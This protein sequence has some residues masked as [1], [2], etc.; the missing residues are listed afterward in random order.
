MDFLTASSIWETHY[1]TIMLR[2]VCGISLCIGLA[3]MIQHSF[4]DFLRIDC[5][6]SSM[7]YILII[8][9][10]GQYIAFLYLT[11]IMWLKYKV[12]ASSLLSSLF[13]PCKIT[14]DMFKMRGSAFQGV[15]FFYILQIAL[16]NMLHRIQ[17][18]CLVIWIK[19]G[20]GGCAKQWQRADLLPFSAQVRYAWSCT[21]TSMSS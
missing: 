5:K 13:L 1:H 12:L 7:L 17:D 2:V 9:K 16:C 11:Y 15:R 6:H 8:S 10:C 21:P 3:C 19:W 14:E 18:V 4:L 20:G